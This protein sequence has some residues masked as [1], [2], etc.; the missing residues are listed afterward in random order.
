[1]A[2]AISGRSYLGAAARGTFAWSGDATAAA[3]ATSATTE[4][5]AIVRRRR[6]TLPRMVDHPSDS[7]LAA[8]K[9]SLTLG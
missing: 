6:I 4:A 5:K 7:S 8:A 1:V 2:E 9:A 3:T